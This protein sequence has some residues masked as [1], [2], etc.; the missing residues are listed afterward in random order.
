L[1]EPAAPD[2]A[3]A[4]Y[5]EAIEEHFRTRRG[6]PLTLS[7]RDFALARGF[8]QAGVALAAVLLGIDRAFEADPGVSSLAFCRRRIEDLASAVVHDQ[9][10]AAAYA[11]VIEE[12]VDSIGCMLRLGLVQKTQHVGFLRNI[13]NVRCDAHALRQ[14]GCSAQSQRL[15]EPARGDVAHGDVTAL[16]D[17]KA[18]ELA[19]HARA[20]PGNDGN[21]AGKLLHGFASFLRQRFGDGCGRIDADASYLRLLAFALAQHCA[22]SGSREGRTCFGYRDWRRH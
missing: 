21:L 18:H 4:A 7:P 1:S 14:S 5:L 17:E 9:A 6:T 12:Q 3:F 16:G 2:P 22:L 15:G 10:S 11:G 20:G 8:Y 13:G 19:P